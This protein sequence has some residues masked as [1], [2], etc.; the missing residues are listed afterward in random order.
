MAKGAISSETEPV[1]IALST[2]TVILGLAEVRRHYF[3]GKHRRLVDLEGLSV[4]KPGNNVG[5]SIVCGIFQQ[6]IKLGGERK[7]P[8]D[9]V[10][11]GCIQRILDCHDIKEAQNFEKWQ[12]DVGS[13][14]E[15]TREFPRK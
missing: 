4:G 9:H 6:L 15:S 3:G 14:D 10:A 2:E 1:D 11:N 8:V 7:L 12:C 13:D 5:G